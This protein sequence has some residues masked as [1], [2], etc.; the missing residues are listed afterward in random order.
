MKRAEFERRQALWAD[1]VRSRG[2]A[3]E[4]IQEGLARDQRDFDALEKGLCPECGAPVRR[5]IS[6]HQHGVVSPEL[7][8]GGWVSYRCS[9][10]PPIGQSRPKGTC[11][12]MLDQWETEGAN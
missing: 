10:Q 8:P 4:D 2:F 3:E 1:F 9:T 5:T 6:P 7:G 11:E 12:Y